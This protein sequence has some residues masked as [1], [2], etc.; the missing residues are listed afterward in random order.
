MIAVAEEQ[1]GK[2]T[3]QAESFQTIFDT[4]P[5]GIVLADGEG[6]LLYFNPAAER[7]LGSPV[8]ASDEVHHNAVYG[9]Y[10]PDQATLIPP[11]RLPL[12]RAIHGEQI[13]GELVFVR[14]F[15]HHDGVW[16]RVHGWPLTDSD[17]LGC[18]GFVVFDDCTEDREAMHTMTLL[19]RALDQTADSVMLTNTQGVIQYVNPAFEATTGYGKE[20]ALGKTPRILKSGMHDAEFYRQMWARLLD[21][22]ASR[23]QIINRKKSGELYWAQQSIT[24]LQNECGQVTHFV[25]V[26]QDVTA[27]RK[28]QEQEFQLQLARD[29]QK[30]LYG[31]PPTMPGIE[32]GT[33][34][35]PASETGGDYFDFLPLGENSLLIA[36]GD[37][38]GHGFGS[39][40][41][42][43]LTRAY[44]RCFAARGLPPNEILAGVNDVLAQDLQPE[45]YV[46]LALARLDLRCRTLSFTSAGHVP[47]FL[48]A[49]NGGVRQILE[50]TG[51]PLG[52]FPESHFGM[53]PPIPLSCGE[54]LVLLTDGIAEAR[55]PEGNPFGTHRILDYLRGHIAEPAQHMVEGLF[56]DVR[57]YL[58]DDLQDDDI[59]SVVVKIDGST[60]SASG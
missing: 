5:V 41:I 25:S 31:Q 40:L 44:L 9:W 15:E 21:G 37:V 23:G 59:T 8:C 39:A 1:P 14:G 29:V 49:E 58:R 28:K 19:A 11:E 36:V 17:G 43:A 53:S 51:P 13:T 20:E 35:H 57:N 38:A 45:Q 6:R 18:G 54:V 47:G 34:S 33:A 30:R 48:L 50:S 10:R 52:L 16:I 42:M 22:Q 3:T 56:H 2:L 24:S 4:L 26:F 46:T 27:L 32:I 60:A 55:S 7:I 12:A